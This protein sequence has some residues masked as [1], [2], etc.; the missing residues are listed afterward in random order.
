M[1]KKADIVLGIVLLLFCTAAS[2]FIAHGSTG[3]STVTVTIDDQVYGTYDLTK[4]QTIPV[5]QSDR[6][7]IL[8]IKDGSISIAEAS[9]SN[10]VCVHQGAISKS[11][12][13]IVCLPNH[14]VVSIDDPGNSQMDAIAY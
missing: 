9:C 13:V 8:Q 12:Q 3:G 1:I 11:R 5:K 10:Q 2:L 6:L 7:N 4:D 14:V